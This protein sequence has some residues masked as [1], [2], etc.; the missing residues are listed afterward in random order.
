[1]DELTYER[2]AR[3]IQR[4][5]IVIAAV[6]GAAAFLLGGW[7]AGFGFLAGALISALSFIWLKGVA[8]ALAGER[9]RRVRSATLAARYLL[10]GCMGYVIFRFVKVSL[11]AVLA[12]VFV[13]TAAVFLEVAFE[14]V[15]ARK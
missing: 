7:K 2:A 3:R 11:P 4:F 12:G 5:M 14:I 1:M 9:P 8:G 6:G 13:L 15:Y 10:L